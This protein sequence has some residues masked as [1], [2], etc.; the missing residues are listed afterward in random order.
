MMQTLS[1]IPGAVAF[2]RQQP[3]GERTR[4]VNEIMTGRC[5]VGTR[6]KPARAGVELLNRRANFIT[7]L[8]QAHVWP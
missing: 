6:E 7:A 5:E 2:V 4:V 1:D 8:A 3:K